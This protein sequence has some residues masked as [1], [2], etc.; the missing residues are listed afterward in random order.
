M[1][2]FKDK[3]GIQSRALSNFLFVFCCLLTLMTQIAA[4]LL[5][6][7]HLDKDNSPKNEN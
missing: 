3:K 4:G 2:I 1:N 7:C 6:F 5:G